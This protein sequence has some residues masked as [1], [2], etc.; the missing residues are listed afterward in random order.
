MRAVEPLDDS[1]LERFDGF[2]PDEEE[3]CVWVD[4]RDRALL[5]VTFEV[6]APDPYAALELGRGVADDALGLLAPAG[7]V[8][9]VS[10][11]DPD[12]ETGWYVDWAPAAP[13]P[14]RRPRRSLW[15]R[16]RP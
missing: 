1:V 2:R 7:H 13:A 8:V 5:H 3:Q 4:Q 12:D 14:V 10:A 15:R 16:G 6:P 9:H 11:T